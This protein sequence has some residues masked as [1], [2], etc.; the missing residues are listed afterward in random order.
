M[1][2]FNSFS[3]LHLNFGNLSSCLQI[4]S[5][6]DWCSPQTIQLESNLEQ[7]SVPREGW[8]NNEKAL[9]G[10]LSKY[11]VDIHRSINV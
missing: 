3:G 4:S 1:C 2:L 11:C 9:I 5:L 7:C 6:A 8:V 10:A